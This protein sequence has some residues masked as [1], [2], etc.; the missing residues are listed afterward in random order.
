MEANPIL[1][2]RKYSRI[3][4]KFSKSSGIRLRDA[5]DF[6]YHSITYKDMSEGLSDMHCRSDDYLVEELQEEYHKV[7]GESCK[8]KK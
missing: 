1:L 8:L 2:Q 3:I 5:L 6:F 7:S 4:V